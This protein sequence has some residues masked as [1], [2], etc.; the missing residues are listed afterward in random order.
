MNI[1]QKSIYSKEPY[2][3]ALDHFNTFYWLDFSPFFVPLSCI[4]QEKVSC[5]LEVEFL[6]LVRLRIEL[7]I[8][9]QSIPH[10]F[11]LVPTVRKRKHMHGSRDVSSVEEAVPIF[12]QDMG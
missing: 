3:L 10:A 4:S 1:K 9:T 2:W 6:Q 7:A 11:H 5:A 12:R 8:N